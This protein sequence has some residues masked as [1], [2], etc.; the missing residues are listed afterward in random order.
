MKLNEPLLH[1]ETLIHNRHKYYGIKHVI[2]TLRKQLNNGTIMEDLKRINALINERNK[3]CT[4]PVDHI[5]LPRVGHGNIDINWFIKHINNY[6]ITKSTLE[7]LNIHT[8]NMVLYEFSYDSPCCTLYDQ[9]QEKFKDGIG[10][11][12]KVYGMPSFCSPSTLFPTTILTAFNSRKLSLEFL[13]FLDINNN[14]ILNKYLFNKLKK[15]CGEA[16][17]K[18]N[19]GLLNKIIANDYH[20]LLVDDDKVFLPNGN[21]SSKYEFENAIY[22]AYKIILWLNFWSK[23]GFK[24]SIRKDIP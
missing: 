13:A 4:S 24:I 9:V 8:D 2:S 23:S 17:I 19:K 21:I 22:I 1:V 7:L 16:L 12:F 18:A 3:H 11:L 14:K 15:Y 20:P 6:S 10:P 5:A